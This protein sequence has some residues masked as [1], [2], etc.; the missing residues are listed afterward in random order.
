MGFAKFANLS[1]Y[2][3]ILHFATNCCVF[4]LISDNVTKRASIVFCS[5]TDENKTAFIAWQLV[6]I[7]DCFDVNDYSD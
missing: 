4:D 5:I 3:E 1:Y 2:R 6:L 7:T